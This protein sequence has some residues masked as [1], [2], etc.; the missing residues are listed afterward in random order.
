MSDTIQKH[1]AIEGVI[2]V[3]K[4]TVAERYAE[5][6][7]ARLVLES[8][9]ENPF[10]EDFYRE[11]GKYAFKVQIFFLLSRYKQLSE[12]P[13]PD[14]F[15]RGLVSDFTFLKDRL[16]A[17]VNLDKH[18]FLLYQEV[19]SIF[20]RLL[21]K[22]DLIIYLQASTDV[23]MERIKRRGRSF[24]HNISREYINQLNE[25]FDD[26]FFH[27]ENSPLLV[28]NTTEID[29]VHQPEHF[30][31]LIKQILKCRSGTHYYVPRGN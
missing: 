17:S 6:V 28:V 19:A 3:G 27:Y 15:H 7:G 14:L 26:Y 5:T 13:P 31:E 2:G 16:F 1:I 22:P 21:R 11:P 9:E 4:T 23:L 20:S 24:E 12:M 25:V 18:E 10:L 8:F 30:G 29:F